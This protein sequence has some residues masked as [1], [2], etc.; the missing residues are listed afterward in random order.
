MYACFPLESSSPGLAN[1][2]AFRGTRAR[3]SCH[4]L[5]AIIHEQKPGSSSYLVV[6]WYSA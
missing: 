6:Q 5:R 4:E 2:A 1:V 3:P